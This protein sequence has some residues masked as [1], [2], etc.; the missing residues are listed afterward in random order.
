MPQDFLYGMEVI[1]H[2]PPFLFL[3][4]DLRVI[5]DMYDKFRTFLNTSLAQNNSV[6]SVVDE[7]ET[8]MN[9]IIS[10]ILDDANNN[11]HKII[12]NIFKL[13]FTRDENENLMSSVF[14]IISNTDYF[15]KYYTQS[16]QQVFYN[17]YN[18][19]ALADL[20]GYIMLQFSYLARRLEEKGNHT[21][22]S[23]LIRKEYEA[24]TNNTML[25]II[26]IMKVTSSKIWRCDPKRH[27]KGRTYDELTALLQGHVENE[28]D[29]N[30][31]GTCRANCAA[32]SYT[33]SYGCYDSKSEYCTKRKPCNGKIINCK[34]V[35]SHM[36]A[37]I[38]P[39]SSPR[40]YEYIE[41]KSG[42]VLGNK[43][44]CS[45]NRNIN[46]WFRWFVHCSYCLC[47][48]DQQGSHSDRY[49]NLRPVMADTAKNRVVTGLRLVK[50]NRII[51]IQIQEGK[52]LPYGYIDNST[53]RWVPIDDYKITDNG[54]KNGIDFHTMNYI[55][56]TMYLD[57][58]VI[59]EA[60]HIITGV[61]FEYVD[62]HLRFEIYVSNFNFDNGTV[63]DGAYYIYGGQGFGKDAAQTTIPFF[64]TQPVAA[65]PALPLKGAG[66]Y[67][68]GK[69]GYGGFVA[70]KISTYDFSKYMQ[71]DLPNSEPRIE[72]EDEFPIVA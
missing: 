46:S 66:I 40:R 54:I 60:H 10:D 48:C 72:T 51:H 57:D 5:N 12:A 55:N 68:K 32:Y 61:R 29:M 1:R 53:I 65:Y 17:L 42:K 52:L 58:L 27:I 71:L 26:S 30:S 59:N 31:K 20:K 63:L 19:I 36:K 56:R 37:C 39:L 67:Y 43:R 70:P 2:A 44:H 22:A 11:V 49:F 3:F 45:N 25:T 7:R 15:C 4:S 50:H 23:L 64:D 9:Y 33:E 21:N 18:Q 35:E 69:E 8:R 13:V 28:V 47:L 14:D 6:L 16:P 38:S 62:N 41:Y 34:F 24:R